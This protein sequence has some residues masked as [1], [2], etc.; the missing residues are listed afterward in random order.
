MLRKNRL[1]G[2]NS[3]R[4]RVKVTGAVLSLSRA[5]SPRASA[6]LGSG[7]GVQ[8]QPGDEPSQ[9]SRIAGGSIQYVSKVCPEDGAGD[10][11]SYSKVWEPRAALLGAPGH[12]QRVELGI[13]WGSSHCPQGPA[14][15]DTVAEILLGIT[16]MWSQGGFGTESNH[17][18]WTTLINQNGKEE[19]KIFL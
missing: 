15:T 7:D 12:G 17:V 16:E 19:R 10:R 6:E 4:K 9:S 3:T 18:C 13:Q 1:R 2:L 14:E 5:Q 11:N 8:K